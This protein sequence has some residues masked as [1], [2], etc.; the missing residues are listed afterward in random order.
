MLYW[1]PTPDTGPAAPR[2][3]PAE[4]RRATSAAH[5]DPGAPARRPKNSR[6]R[7]A[8]KWL[9][10]RTDGAP[11]GHAPRNTLAALAASPTP[12]DDTD[13][14]IAS[15]TEHF[16]AGRTVKAVDAALQAACASADEAPYEIGGSPQP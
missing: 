16:E 8:V 9:R 11:Q 6:P 2:R 1:R 13:R 14:R 10:A 7:G 15:L 5:N 3:P 12:K 4:Y